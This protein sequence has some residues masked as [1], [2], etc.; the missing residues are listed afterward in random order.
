[1]LPRHQQKKIAVSAVISRLHPALGAEYL[2]IV[3][4]LGMRMQVKVGDQGLGSGIHGYLRQVRFPLA[5]M[6]V[7]GKWFERYIRTRPL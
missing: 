7:R 4:A 6:N 1:M 2:P 5:G 3:A